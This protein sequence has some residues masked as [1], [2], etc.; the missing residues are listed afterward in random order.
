LVKGHHN[1]PQETVAA[2][3][4]AVFEVDTY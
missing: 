4:D 2:F 1:L 3:A